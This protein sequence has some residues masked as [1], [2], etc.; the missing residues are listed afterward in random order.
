ME[1]EKFM[2]YLSLYGADTESWPE[3]ASTQAQD[4]LSESAELREALRAEREFEAALNLRRFEEPSAGLAGR[5]IEAAA[6]D[7]KTSRKTSV[8]DKI[9]SVFGA[10]PIPRP[11]FAIPLLLF[12]GITAG[13]LYTAHYDDSTQPTEVAS[14]IFYE[15]GLYE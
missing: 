15:E 8:F 7:G 6:L 14:V 12:I 2:E 13:Y 10:L 11:A 5:I 1:K 4:A 3:G 9:S